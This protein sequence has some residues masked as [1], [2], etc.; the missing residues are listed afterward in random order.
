MMER[1]FPEA[2]APVEGAVLPPEKTGAV[3]VRAAIRNA[4]ARDG[5]NSGKENVL[6]IKIPL[7]SKFFL[8]RTPGQSRRDKRIAATL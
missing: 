1:V 7:Y 4:A 5:Q 2:P 3:S 6:F 8:S